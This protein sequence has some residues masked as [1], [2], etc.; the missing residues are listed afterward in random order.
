V[1]EGAPHPGY[2]PKTKATGYFLK[3]KGRM[4]VSKDDYQVVKIEA[5]TID[6]IS[7]G[8]FLVRLH[9]GARVRAQYARV[10]DEVW[11]PKYVGLTG[12]ARFLL[13]K[14][15]R[16]DSDMAFTNYRKFS[17]DSRVVSTGQ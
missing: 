2:K 8:A 17:T 5:E 16:I 13:V 9:K 6:T 10:N 14:G 1:I 4:W 3:M 12:S 11:L 7:I 15:M